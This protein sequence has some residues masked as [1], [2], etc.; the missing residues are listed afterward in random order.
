MTARKADAANDTEW[1]YYTIVYSGLHGVDE[2]VGLD[3][4]CELLLIQN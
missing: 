4:A 2:R 3:K 1:T